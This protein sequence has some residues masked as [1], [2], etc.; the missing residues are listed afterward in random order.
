NYLDTALNKVAQASSLHSFHEQDAR[1]TIFFDP[2]ISLEI[3]QR[4]LPHWRQT[5]TTYYVT[6][7]LADSLPQEKVQQLKLEREKWLKSHPEPRSPSVTAEYHRLF[8]EKVEQWLDA[9]AGSCI[10]REPDAAKIVADALTHFDGERYRLGEWV[11]MP[12]HVHVLVTPLHKHELSDILHSWK[13]FAANKINEHLHR[14]GTLWQHESYDHIV[15]S[16]DQLHRIEQYIRDNPAKAG[17]KVAQA[18]SLHSENHEQDARATLV[19]RADIET[20]VHLGDQAA[21]YE[22]ARMSGTKS[23]KPEL[24]KS[25]ETH[26]RFIDEKL[27]DI[28]VC[29]P[30]VGSGAFPV[31]MMTEIVRSRSALT[32]YFNDIH[33]RT[34]YHFKRH[35]IQNCLYGVDIDAGAVEIA[36]LR[37]WLSLVVDEEDAKQIKPLPNLDYKVVA[38]N[39]LLGVERNIFNN[40]LFLQ[41][42]KLKPQYFDE[43]DTNRKASL[44]RQ[45]DGLI[46]QLTTDNEIFDFEIYFSEVFHNGGGFDIT[47][48]NPPYV[49]QEKLKDQ[50]KVFAQ[51]YQTY[52]GI[53]DLYVY[54]YEKG[55]KLLKPGGTIAYIS[56]NKFFRAGYGEKLR[57]FL[58]EKTAIINLIDFG[59]LPVFEATTYP[60]VLVAKRLNG[61]SRETVVRARTI[62]SEDELR[63]FEDVF[64]SSAIDMP[65]SSLSVEGW[66]IENKAML[67]LLEK[68][69]KGGVPLGEY[70]TGKIYRGIITGYNEAFVIDEETK[71]RL[72][73]E[74]KRSAQVIKPLLRG[75]DIKRYSIEEPGLYLIY[76]PHKWTNEHRGK[77]EPED[78]FKKELPAIHTHLKPSE[79]PLTKRDD[80]G[81]YWWEM[82]PCKYLEEFEKPKIVWG[83]LGDVAGF[84]YDEGN[85]YPS[86]PACLIQT[87]DMFLLADLNSSLG[88]Y[89]F[90]QIAAVRR[91]GYLEYKPMYVEQLPIA[92]PSSVQRREI[93]SCIKKILKAKKLDPAADTVAWEREIDRLVY[94]LYSLTEDEI[95]IVEGATARIDR[96]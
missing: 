95:S 91:G 53:A 55:I 30:A 43:S 12:N 24:P 42:E 48:A 47:L 16:D 70:V 18:S 45:I 73:K 54:F 40:N 26:A 59:D 21:H 82:R 11:V 75:R 58:T 84:G 74:D 88:D 38:G 32:P 77:T 37:L 4:N 8:S 83:N 85:C 90:H 76:V 52:T 23:Y 14:T 92:I 29:D 79:K 78:F 65:Q 94:E 64:R 96:G 25:I 33:E 51:H 46:Y 22:A 62:A 67:S 44:K 3:Y 1:A 81:E 60:C 49:R 87:E 2:N 35:A 34:P 10:L 68:I 71:K 57:R 93:E 13:S 28:T 61:E 15:R 69:R 86:A 72:I 39:S 5:G 20:F 56:S 89:F 17:I 31:G 36:K 63:R 27:P 9:G 19:P 66:R 80:Q 7:R 50:K 6:F 41:L